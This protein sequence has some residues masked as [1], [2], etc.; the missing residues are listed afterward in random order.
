MGT[1]HLSDKTKKKII[2]DRVNGMSFRKLAEKYNISTT[3]AQ[4]VVRSDPELTQKVTRKKEENAKSM[5]EFLD[6]QS[7]SAQEFVRM[8]LEAI[9]DPAKLE[10]ASVQTIATALGIVIDK[11]TTVPKQAD[12]GVEMIWGRLE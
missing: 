2:A 4:R 9:K 3:T 1:K 10:R 7:E 5:L 11:F 6:S 12:E 8:A